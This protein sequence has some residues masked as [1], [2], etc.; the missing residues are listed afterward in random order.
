[1]LTMKG[2][3]YRVFSK[4]GRNLFAI[5]TI[6]LL[7]IEETQIPT[8]TYTNCLRLNFPD[9]AAYLQRGTF[10][11]GSPNKIRIRLGWGLLRLL[12]RN[13]TGAAFGNPLINRAILR[14]A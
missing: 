10:F 1:M 5:R 6:A 13:G 7:L 8:R 14:N 4:A 9:H 2:V 12:G 3:P 11:R